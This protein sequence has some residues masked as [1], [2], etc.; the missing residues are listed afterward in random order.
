MK[1]AKKS[2]RKTDT[3]SGEGEETVIQGGGHAVKSFED[4]V[5]D[6]PARRKAEERGGIRV[7]ER[8]RPEHTRG[9][10]GIKG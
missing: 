2:R 4:S 10:Q 9:K 6:G 3:P 7:D 1:Q 5:E 8:G